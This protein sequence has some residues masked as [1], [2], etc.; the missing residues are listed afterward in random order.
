MNSRNGQILILTPTGH[1]YSAARS[2]F[3][4]ELPVTSTTHRSSIFKNE[5][6]LLQCGHGKIESALSTYDYLM[7]HPLVTGC[8]LIGVGG[9]LDPRIQRGDLVLANKIVEYDYQS[10]RQVNPPSFKTSSELLATLTKSLSR[11]PTSPQ[12]WIGGIASGD[13]DVLSA[14]SRQYLYE[15]TQCLAVAWE[16]AGIARACARLK[17]PYLELRSIS[18]C[19]TDESIHPPEA[20]DIFRNFLTVF[21]SALMN[22]H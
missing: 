17:K 7:K 10:S 5:I 9:G 1:E 20:L 16:G 22:N 4:D 21:R 8:S 18:D 2:V 3:S 14:S 13:Q 11:L 15:Q 19:S 6:H 12:F